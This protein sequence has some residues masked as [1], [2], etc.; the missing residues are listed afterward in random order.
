MK[1]R[2]FNKK[3]VTLIEMIVSVFVLSIILVAITTMFIPVLQ[4]YARANNLAEANTLL[5][6][7]SL[8]IMEDVA[9]ATSVTP[10]PADPD[11]VLPDETLF[12]IK[13][14]YYI[15]Y[16]TNAS[17][18][19]CRRTGVF[20]APLLPADFYKKNRVTAACTIDSSLVTITLT[21]YAADGWEHERSYSARPVGL[22]G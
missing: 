13:T 10:G 7:I 4:T 1:K 17:G 21:L 11:I 9:N 8:L 22:Q 15:E 2:L 12:T 6:N 3:G 19:L 20:D 16:Y 5:D 18:I 14:S